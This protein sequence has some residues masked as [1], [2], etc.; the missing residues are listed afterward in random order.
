MAKG[1][2]VVDEQRCKGCAL[3]ISAC[4][5][6]VLSMAANRLNARGYHPVQLIDPDGRC[7]G[8]GLCAVMCPDVS[9]TVYRL[10]EAPKQA[11]VGQML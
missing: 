11:I 10:V 4:P 8:C 1:R 9:L 3:C 2:V 5:P 7:T 6:G